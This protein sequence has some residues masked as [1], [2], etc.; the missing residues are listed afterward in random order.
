M[1]VKLIRNVLCIVCIYDKY[2]YKFKYIEF[3]FFF[4][5]LK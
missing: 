3:F 2:K 5:L 1:L 4:L